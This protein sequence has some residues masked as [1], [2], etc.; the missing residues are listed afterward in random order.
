MFFNMFQIDPLWLTI[1]SDL[2]VNLAAG[3]FGAVIIVPFIS[4]RQK[5]PWW[6]LIFN[7]MSGILA[8]FIAYF[9]RVAK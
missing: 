3:W 6:L 1:F 8:L 4:R 5:V 2:F 9:L 7:V